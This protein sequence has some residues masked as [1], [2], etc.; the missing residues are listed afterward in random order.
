MKS[1]TIGRSSENDVV[2]SDQFVSR[3]HCQ[4]IQDDN[5][6]YR[7]IDLQSQGG[8]YVN[9]VKRH[10]EVSL[11]DIDIVRIGNSTVPWLSYFKD[12][13]PPSTKT[14]KSGGFG[15]AAF[16]CGILSIILVAIPF[17]VIGWQ[18]DRKNRGLAIAGFI[19]GCA[20]TLIWII[21]FIA[22]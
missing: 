5:G 18:P 21:I 12:N 3:K 14:L 17:G 2:I 9:G 16:V 6:G 1:I 13:K 15:I 22:S 4:I 8:T 19:L 10:G 7:L 20:W 11:N